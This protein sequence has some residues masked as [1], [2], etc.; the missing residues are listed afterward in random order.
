MGKFLTLVFCMTALYALSPL[1]LA[2]EKDRG[3][4]RYG[5]TY[6]IAEDREI[7]KIGGV[8][9]PEG[10]DKYMKRKFDELSSNLQRLDARLAA[11]E[12]RFSEIT[13][14]LEDRSKKERPVSENNRAVVT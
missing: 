2:E 4:T 1:V 12:T 13:G 10:L 9:E 8:Y 7:E 6:N 14:L 11:L 3:V 5:V